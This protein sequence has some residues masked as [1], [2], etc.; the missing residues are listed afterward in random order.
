MIR[1][2]NINLSY[3]NK[4][5]IIENLNLT[6]NDNEFLVIIGPSGCGKSSLVKMLSGLIKPTSGN[7]FI[8][9]KL[10]NEAEPFNRGISFMQQNAKPYPHLSVFDNIAFPLQLKKLDKNAI[11]NKVEEIADKLSIK[12]YLS[13][14]PKELSGGEYQR[15]NLARTLVLDNNIVIFDEP[16]SSL[17]YNLK[18][19]MKRDIKEL[20]KLYNHTTIYI[21]HDRKEAMSLADRIVLMKDGK[22]IQVGTP[23]ELYLN[24]INTF[25][26][27]FLSKMNYINHDNYIIG[28]R[29]AD[30]SLDGDL[31]VEIIDSEIVDGKKNVY[32]KL[33]NEEIEFIVDINRELKKEEF[34]KINKEYIFDFDTKMRKDMD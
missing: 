18:D 2:E 23:M 34:I 13:R 10:V 4:T 5:N 29:P 7:I 15:L 31:K 25:S 3:D 32:A 28:F 12:P 17:D 1:F 6:I 20:H 16:L 24:P 22:I 21:T 26:A 33:D 30:V 14:L 8:D 19:N 27:S 9:D 11:K